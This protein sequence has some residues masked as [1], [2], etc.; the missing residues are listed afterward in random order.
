[1][2]SASPREAPG[3]TSPTQAI[4][5]PT[6]GR[7]L[8]WPIALGAGALA[9]GGAA[10]AFHL[11][12]DSTYERAK[13]AVDQEERESL[14]QSANNKRYLA[15]GFGVAA[16]GAAGAAVYFTLRGGD[17]RASTTAMTPVVSP[18][19]AGVALVGRW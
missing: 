4:D 11:S 5:Q 9:F 18:Q 17:S 13:Q 6:R 12:G 8:V 3:S 7:S 10:V 14:Y 1:V 19:L 2:A 15:Q 16:L